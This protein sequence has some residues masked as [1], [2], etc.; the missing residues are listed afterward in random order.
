MKLSVKDR[1]LIL[2]MLPDEANIITMRVV[3]D[4]KRDLGF[5]EAESKSLSFMSGE[6]WEAGCPNCK[7][8]DL[9]IALDKDY[10]V[11]MGKCLSCNHKGL[12]IANQIGWNQ[13]AAKEEDIEIG[14]V[15]KKII[16]EQ[17]EA[18]DEQGKIIPDHLEICEKFGL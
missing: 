15:A 13:S 10:G 12:I 11:N 1:L 4:L 3:H 5:S 16:R 9:E 6:S 17:F 18:L 14:D 8:Q 7:G 2:Q